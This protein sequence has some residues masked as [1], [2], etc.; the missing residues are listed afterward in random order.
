M[1]M[2]L[3]CRYIIPGPKG[4][5][6]KEF[7][8]DLIQTPTDASYEILGSGIPWQDVMRRYLAWVASQSDR[9]VCKRERQR[10]GRIWREVEEANGRVIFEVW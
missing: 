7:K 6:G 5:P 3:H 10:M 8:V 1:S 2:N 9:S 4:K